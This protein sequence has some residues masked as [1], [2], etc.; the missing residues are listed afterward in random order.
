MEFSQHTFSGKRLLVVD[1]VEVFRYASDLLRIFVFENIF[2]NFAVLFA[3][4]EHEVQI[5]WHS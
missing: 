5:D 4:R 3:Q 2:V 1:G